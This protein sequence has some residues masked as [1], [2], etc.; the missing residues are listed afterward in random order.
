MK[1][2]FTE[3]FLRIVMVPLVRKNIFVQVSGREEDRAGI[4]VATDVLLC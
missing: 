4:C 1:Q 3:N 2:N